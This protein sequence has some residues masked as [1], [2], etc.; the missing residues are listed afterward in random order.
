M[1]RGPVARILLSIF[2][3]ALL[4]TPIVVRRVSAGRASTKIKLDANA[5]LARHSFY[6]Q[7]VSRTAGINFVHQAPTLDAKLDGIMPQVASMGASV[8]IVDFDRDG[9]PD[10][11]V[12][13]SKE[14]S[15]TPS[16]ATCMTA[17][18]KT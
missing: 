4:A 8:S 3:V 14:G 18:L 5:A 16:I 2:F 15:K 6:L 7:D 10:I 12:T 17:P 9:W 13:N 1:K 11:Y